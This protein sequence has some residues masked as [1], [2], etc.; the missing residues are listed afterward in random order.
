[1]DEGRALEEFLEDNPGAIQ[2]ILE[3]IETHMNEEWDHSIQEFLEENSE[4]EE[5]EEV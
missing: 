1:M 4:M 2:A 3:F 5:E